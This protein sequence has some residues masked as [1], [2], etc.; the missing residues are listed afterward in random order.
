[1]PIHDWTRVRANRFH[2]FHQSW[3][4]ALSGQ[5]NR[6]RLPQGYYSLLEE[7]PP[8]LAGLNVNADYRADPEEA[9]YASKANSITI[10]APTDRVVSV[11]EVVS[12][13]NKSSR[14]AHDNF[15]RQAVALLKA[16]VNLV[17][18]DLFPTGKQDGMGI[19]QSIWLS[20]SGGETLGL[21]EDKPLVVVSYQAAREAAAYVDPVAVGE[22]LPD[23]P[24]FLTSDRYV[25]CPL[26]ES[27]QTAWGQFPPPLRGPLESPP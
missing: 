15:V 16:S 1:M 18:V 23:M 14:V 20:L 8:L 2:D 26:E 24:V 22:E 25:L 19:H 27:Y 11:I 17:V 5:L 7:P 21:P 12:P 6:G 9:R 4:A 10:R 13:G 3:T